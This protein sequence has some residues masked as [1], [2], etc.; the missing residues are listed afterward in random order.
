MTVDRKSSYWK[1]DWIWQ[2]RNDL[3]LIVMSNGY[4]SWNQKVKSSCKI[5]LIRLMNAFICSRNDHWSC[6]N[7]FDGKVEWTCIDRFDRP[8]CF[9]AE[10]INNGI[11]IRNKLLRE[12]EVLYSDEFSIAQ[13]AVEYLTKSLGFHILMTKQDISQSIFTADEA[14]GT[15]TIAVSV[16]WRLYLTSSI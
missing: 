14:V 1:R 4:L 6:G 10:N 2:K 11:V 9:S 5:Y 15:I 7:C 3:I 12:I 16:K 8:H 13:W